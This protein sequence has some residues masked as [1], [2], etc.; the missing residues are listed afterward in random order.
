VLELGQRRAQP[1]QYLS[2]RWRDPVYT[3]V[4]RSLGFRRTQ[5][6]TASHSGEQRIQR[7]GT[8]S[9]AVPLQLLQH[10]LPVH[11]LLFRMMQNVDL[12]ESK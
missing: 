8:E 12:P 2:T 11:T 9:I 5:P 1:L 3:C 10:P 4:T 7:A 6:T